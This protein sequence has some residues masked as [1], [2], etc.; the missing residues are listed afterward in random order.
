MSSVIETQ[1]NQTTQT[2]QSQQ[3]NT[4][5]YLTSINKS[6]VK[7]NINNTTINSNNIKEYIQHFKDYKKSIESIIGTLNTRIAKINQNI[8]KPKAEYK[9]IKNNNNKLREKQKLSQQIHILSNDLTILTAKKNKVSVLLTNNIASFT[10]KMNTY[11]ND[12]Y[13]KT[14]TNYTASLTKSESN[15]DIIKNSFDKLISNNVLN[16]VNI[17]K[18]YNSI[19]S[20]KLQNNIQLKKNFNNLKGTLVNFKNININTT[21]KAF[22]TYNNLYK[23]NS[24][25]LT[26][27]SHNINTRIKERISKF[28][29]NIN[30]K[31]E[32]LK[33]KIESFKLKINE[34]QKIIEPIG[35]NVFS[36]GQFAV[37]NN[38]INELTQSITD[39]TTNFDSEKDKLKKIIESLNKLLGVVKNN[40]N[41][42]IGAAASTNNPTTNASTIATNA[43]TNA[44]RT[45]SSNTKKILSGNKSSNNGRLNK[46]LNSLSMNRLLSLI[47]NTRNQ[48][49]AG[50]PLNTKNLISRIKEK[51]KGNQSNLN[52]K[53]AS[54]LAASKKSLQN[55]NKTT[56][57]VMRTNTNSGNSGGNSGEKSNG[58][59][60]RVGIAAPLSISQTIHSNNANQSTPTKI[61][62]LTNKYAN[63]L[64]TFKSSNGKGGEKLSTRLFIKRNQIMN[65]NGKPVMNNKGNPTYV[66]VTKV[67]K[68][69]TFSENTS[70]IY[71]SNKLLYNREISIL[72][73]V[74]NTKV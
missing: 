19:T 22:N 42:S 14:L 34:L 56:T 67:K 60:A 1:T 73:K 70:N 4:N 54:I 49:P 44:A 65:A 26:N 18:K 61:S 57:Q 39:S 29:A 40:G 7:F 66:I 5:S 58:A 35:P 50:T 9:A 63:R 55:N 24:I 15:L 37:L 51:Y 47:P 28:N 62:Q 43:S 23:T 52:K 17:N 16:L 3:N 8:I 11:I 74:E 53:L 68:N 46:N 72:P 25:K 32:T 31:T 13:I 20:T 71:P 64:F 2:N 36:P 12:N 69:K 48:P 41:A 45:S 27:I 6:L 30:S 21:K 59:N 38:M 33:Q 10:A